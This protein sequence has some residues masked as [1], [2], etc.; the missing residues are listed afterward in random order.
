MNHLFESFLVLFA[1][2]AAFAWP[3]FLE[4]WIQARYNLQA[5]QTKN[6][7]AYLEAERQAWPDAVRWA[8]DIARLADI[9]H[10]ESTLYEQEVEEGNR[11]RRELDAFSHTWKP[12]L[13]L[14]LCCRKGRG[15]YRAEAEH[16]FMRQF[17]SR[18]PLIHAK[19]K[20][21]KRRER[22]LQFCEKHNMDP[23]EV[24]RIGF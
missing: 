15:R 17:K 19:K 5:L 4:R 9:E 7:N 13:A 24:E 10:A 11:K 22:I 12:S 1:I 8:Q 20:A 3:F 14:R 18:L 16:D 21:L 23:A 2:V 6:R